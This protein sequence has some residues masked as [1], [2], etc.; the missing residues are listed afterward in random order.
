M[1]AQAELLIFHRCSAKVAPGTRVAAKPLLRW[2]LR[3]WVG[4][5]RKRGSHRKPRAAEREENNDVARLAIKVQRE[6]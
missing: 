4:S 5:A 1:M 3:K 6:K 2:E